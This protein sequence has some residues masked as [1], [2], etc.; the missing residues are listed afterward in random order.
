MLLTCPDGKER[1]MKHFG[2]KHDELINN[3]K[4]TIMKKKFFFIVGGM[5]VFALPVVAQPDTLTKPDRTRT[6]QDPKITDDKSKSKVL[7]D[8]SNQVADSLLD[9]K[10]TGRKKHARTESDPMGTSDRPA[11]LKRAPADSSHNN[12]L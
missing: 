10:K 8:T 3:P 1:Q 7:L 11:R 6:Y 12:A 4:I 9:Q 2:I 5:M